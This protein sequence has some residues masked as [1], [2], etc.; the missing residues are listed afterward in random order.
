MEKW[1]QLIS[2][3]KLS[4]M[5]IMELNVLLEFEQTT[6]RFG[7]FIEKKS[8]AKKHTHGSTYQGIKR[9]AIPLYRRHRNF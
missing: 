7:I 4:S 3:Y 9:I 5:E 8:Q 6:F 1:T 2:T